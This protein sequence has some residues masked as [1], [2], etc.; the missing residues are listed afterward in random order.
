MDWWQLAL[1]LLLI[2]VNLVVVG[3]FLGIFRVNIVQFS[4]L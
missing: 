3:L 4:V 1:V 2:A